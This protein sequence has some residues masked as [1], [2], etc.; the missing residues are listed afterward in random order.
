MRDWNVRH[1]KI[2]LATWWSNWKCSLHA[3]KNEKKP[4][5]VTWTGIV[6]EKKKKKKKP[7]A[8]EQTAK[9]ISCNNSKTSQGNMCLAYLFWKVVTSSK[10]VQPNKTALKMKAAIA[11]Q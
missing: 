2:I 10:I 5:V 7:I 8:Q 9:I 4:C 6:P 3:E 11:L 1:Y